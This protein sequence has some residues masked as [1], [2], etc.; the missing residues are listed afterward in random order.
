M[1]DLA[2]ALDLGV[3]EVTS[4]LV[5]T[6][7]NGMVIPRKVLEAKA[8]DLLAKKEWGSFNAILALLVY[9]LVLFPKVND[10]I[11]MPAIGVFLV[12]SPVH[13][14]LAD[15]HLSLCSRHEKRRGGTIVCCTPLMQLWLYSHLPKKGFFVENQDQFSWPNR[16]VALTEKDIAW[17]SREYDGTKIILRCGGF[18]N[19]PLIVPRGCINYNPVLSL[20]QLGYSMEGKP[21][22]RHV[23][24]FILKEGERDAALVNRIKKAWG[25]VYEKEKEK[26][27]CIAK[28][29]YTQWV[30]ERVAMF[31]LRYPVVAREELSSPPPVTTITIEEATELKNKVVEL[32]GK[33]EEMENKYLQVAEKTKLEH[34]QNNVQSLLSEH[35]EA[36]VSHIT[37]LKGEIDNLKLELDYR[38]R[39]LKHVWA[40]ATE[41]SKSN[42]KLS[43]DFVEL[44]AFSKAALDDI[45][46][47]LED[48]E[49]DMMW[50]KP[51]KGIQALIEYCRVLLN[52]YKKARE[53]AGQQ[54]AI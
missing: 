26:K 47:K 15:F 34:L 9:G 36:H 19:V 53:T 43:K 51:P 12:G 29:P 27:N 35:V 30:K 46:D 48:A 49:V 39:V 6:K 44:T 20:R 22:D 11:D 37:S 42:A 25:Q 45:P 2:K 13:A 52:T 16:M 54:T 17:Y 18:P 8:S 21:E 28:P 32:E 10:S 14:L 38:G 3:E 24:E 33:N 7:D 40:D 4:W 1:D 31:R 23:E 5:K 41:L 50:H